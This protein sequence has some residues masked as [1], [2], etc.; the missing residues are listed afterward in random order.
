MKLN[1]RGVVDVVFTI[2]IVLILVAGGIVLYEIQKDRSDDSADQEVT[3]VGEDSAP[4][5]TTETEL[6]SGATRVENERFSIELPEGWVEEE[7][8]P[9]TIAGVP[10]VYYSYTD[11]E[12][13]SIGISIN[14]L[15]FGGAGD[16]QA[17]FSFIG[18]EITFDGAYIE[19]DPEAI[20]SGACTVGDGT[21]GLYLTSSEG[22]NGEGYLFRIIDENEESQAAY[23]RLVDILKTITLN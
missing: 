7:V 23:L 20:L 9:S 3:S 1:T 14:S 18:N 10:E 11:G 5:D 12:G 22:Y 8:D 21:L 2:A 4:A 19:C 17:G 13:R 15:G 6:E 16:G